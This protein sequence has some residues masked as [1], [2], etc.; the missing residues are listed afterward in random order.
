M[1]REGGSRSLATVSC[2]CILSQNRSFLEP[3]STLLSTSAS[4][5]KMLDLQHTLSTY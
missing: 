1:S 2:L 4:C 3:V 5:P